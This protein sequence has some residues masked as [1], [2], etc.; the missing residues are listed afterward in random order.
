[1]GA[2]WRRKG[3]GSDPRPSLRRRAAR[4]SRSSAARPR[5]APMESRTRG[6]FLTGEW[7]CLAML[8]YEVDPGF[9]VRRET[10]DGEVRRAVTFISELVPR[11]AIAALARL[12]YNEPYRAL[13]M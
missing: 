11:R 13:P 9:Y 6:V 7:R 4:R 5:R 10:E 2:A 1:M 8:N 12:A 3:A